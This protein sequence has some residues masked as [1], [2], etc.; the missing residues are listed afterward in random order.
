M[1]REDSRTY[2]KRG[3]EVSR[4]CPAC[5]SKRIWRDGIRK[6]RNSSV[7]RY[8]CRDCDHKFSES[9]ALSA[10]QID[11]GGCQV[12]APLVGARNLAKVEPPNDELG[13]FVGRSICRSGPGGNRTHGRHL[14][15]VAS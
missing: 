15:R 5:H 7:Q 10:H 4:E 9:S 8:I 14:V 6:I 1:L 2:F 12:C 3:E 11:S 13:F